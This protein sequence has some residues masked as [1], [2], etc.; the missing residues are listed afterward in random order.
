MNSPGHWFAQVRGSSLGSALL[1][2]VF[3]FLLMGWCPQCCSCD[4]CSGLLLGC[5]GSIGSGRVGL[6][7]CGLNKTEG[8]YCL[9]TGG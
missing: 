4:S 5:A 9:P 2:L 7:Y 1:Q 6:W 3:S 8:I